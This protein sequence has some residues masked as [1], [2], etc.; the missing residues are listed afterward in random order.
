[1]RSNAVQLG[2]KTEYNKYAKTLKRTLDLLASE[3]RI[4]TLEDRVLI[5]SSRST[6]IDPSLKREAHAALQ[7]IQTELR[8]YTTYLN[9]LV[10]FR[11]QYTYYQIISQPYKSIAACDKALAYLAERPHL[12]PP[13]RIGEFE[14]YR[15]D[16]FRLVRDYEKGT[17]AA[18]RC[19]KI[20]LPGTNIW[21]KAKEAQFLLLMQTEKFSDANEIY[22][23]VITHERYAVQLEHFREKWDI[24]GVYIEYLMDINRRNLTPGKSYLLRQKKYKRLINEFPTYSKD[25]RGLN[26]AM[27][28][29]NILLLLENDKLEKI[30]KQVDALETYRSRHLKGDYSHQSSILFKLIKLL[31]SNDYD[32]SRIKE[33]AS[34]L[35]RQLAATKASPYEIFE[36]IQI[37]PPEWVWKRMKEILGKR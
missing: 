35:E 20:F 13:I 3:V 34:V 11:M 27:L 22:R 25:K 26:V 32:L 19:E 2:N 37:L 9:K 1:M 6:F 33:K 4:K 5:N 21:F 36:V 17:D 18:L 16:N 24:F 30:V 29:L 31:D 23:Q 15:L 28:I 12:A 7:L 8:S 10:N 14:L